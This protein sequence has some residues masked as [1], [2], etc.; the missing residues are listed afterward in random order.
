MSGGDWKEF[1]KAAVDG[2]T[3]LVEHHLAADIDVDYAHPEFLS[4]PLVAAILA[5]SAHRLSGA[6]ADQPICD[7][8]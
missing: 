6:P 4:T 5:G 2:D 8:R 1:F 7:C 3:A